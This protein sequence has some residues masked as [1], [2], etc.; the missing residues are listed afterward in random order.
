METIIYKIELSSN[1]GIIFT[2][3][4]KGFIISSE[5]VSTSKALHFARIKGLSFMEDSGEAKYYW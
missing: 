3:T 5:E 2:M 1:Y 4:T